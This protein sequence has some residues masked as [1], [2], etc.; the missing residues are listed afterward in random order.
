[1]REQGPGIVRKEIKQPGPDG[2][3]P[4]E[5]RPS[6]KVVTAFVV[7]EPLVE[8]QGA[9]SARLTL[10]ISWILHDL[11]TP[12]TGVIGY[13]S[14]LGD[15]MSGRLG[16]RAPDPAQLVPHIERNGTRML[17]VL[18][19]ARDYLLGESGQLEIKKERVELGDVAT[20]AVEIMRQRA[21]GKKL[22]LQISRASLAYAE[23]DQQLLKHVLISLIKSSVM[24]TQKDGR[25]AVSTGTDDGLAIIRVSDTG[26]AVTME[27]MAF[28]LD[29]A[30]AASIRA[31]ECRGLG[32]VVA[33]SFAERMGGTVSVESAEGKG[34]TFT[35]AFPL[36]RQEP[37]H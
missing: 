17:E 13:A 26:M 2:T 31:V 7:S 4:K 36:A 5:K 21:E 1:M 12:L 27:E 28:A 23:V 11:R 22:I 34:T 9:A 29:P 3:Q 37:Q 18:D 19:L 25:I 20:M 8:Q 6:G 15:A 14:L 10:I 32:F 24:C 33:K 30:A 35:V 16:G